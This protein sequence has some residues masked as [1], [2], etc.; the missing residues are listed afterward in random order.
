[1]DLIMISTFIRSKHD[2]VWCV[3]IHSTQVQRFGHT[4]ELNIRTCIEMAVILYVNHIYVCKSVYLDLYT[5]KYRHIRKQICAYIVA[6]IHTIVY[7]HLKHV[8]ISVFIRN[9]HIPYSKVMY[10]YIHTYLYIRTYIY[11]YI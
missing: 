7:I 5:S 3:C 10:I 8:Q 11:V 4:G 1:M 2:A 6:F 9:I